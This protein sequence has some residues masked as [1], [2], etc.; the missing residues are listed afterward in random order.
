MQMSLIPIYPRGEQMNTEVDSLDLGPD[1]LTVTTDTTHKTAFLRVAAEAYTADHKQTRPW[2]FLGYVGR[3]WHD[4]AGKGGIAYGE[5][6]GGTLGILQTWGEWSNVVGHQLCNGQN[7]VTRC[8]LQVTVLHKAP[9][10]NVYDLVAGLDGSLHKYTAIVPVGPEGGTLY[11]GSRAS[12]KFGRMYDKGAQLKGDIPLRTLWRYEVEYKR[13][14]A[15]GI[16]SVLWAHDMD[17]AGRREYIMHSVETFFREHG[18]PTPFMAG[19]DSHHA[20]VRY[21]TRQ[22]DAERTLQ[23]LSQQVHP[24]VLRLAYG[25]HADAVALALGLTVKD[26]APSWETVD[27]IPA[28]QLDFF[29]SI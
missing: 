11:I 16:A 5:R 3:T 4:P 2:R 19:S 29:G 23:W 20:V 17:P 18:I 1:W 6:N 27:I 14:V 10:E 26:G 13:K 15:R 22:E 8:D 24:A 25:G 7:R 9:T 12:D 21:A 28:E